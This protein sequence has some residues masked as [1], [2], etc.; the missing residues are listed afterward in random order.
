[1]FEMKPAVTRPEHSNDGQNPVA[2]ARLHCSCLSCTG[3]FLVLSLDSEELE[4][5]SAFTLLTL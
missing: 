1:M 5:E 3:I 4:S 2:P